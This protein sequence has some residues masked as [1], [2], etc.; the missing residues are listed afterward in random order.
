VARAAAG[1]V[2]AL[3]DALKTAAL[4]LADDDHLLVDLEDV[5]GLDLLAQLDLRH[6]LGGP[7][8]PQHPGRRGVGLQEMAAARLGHVLHRP[9]L[10]QTQ[11]DGLV[12]V[13]LQRFLLDDHAGAQLYHRHGNDPSVFVKD[14]SHAKL[15]ANQ[16]FN[17]RSL[18]LLIYL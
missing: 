15:F 6:R 3:D 10:H 12:A 5:V 17:H 2:V 16:S 9:L 4:A 8:F 13:F 1:E 11:L 18:Q 7:E 14:L